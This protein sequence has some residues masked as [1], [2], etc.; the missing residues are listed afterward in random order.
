MIPSCMF[1]YSF[2][3]PFFSFLQIYIYIYVYIYIHTYMYGY[4]IKNDSSENCN[5]RLE[6]KKDDMKKEIS[7]INNLDYE[8]NIKEHKISSSEAFERNDKN[9]YNEKSMRNNCIE[10][11]ES[12]LYKEGSNK[13][14]CIERC[15]GREKRGKDYLEIS[16][17]LIYSRIR[18]HLDKNKENS[19]VYIY[20]KIILYSSLYNIVTLCD[21]YNYIRKN[22]LSKH[23]PKFFLYSKLFIMI[24]IKK[25]FYER[26]YIMCY[27]LSKLLLMEHMYDSFTITFFV[28]SS[29]LLNKISCI[30]NLAV[31]LRRNKKYIYYLFCNAALL[32]HFRQVERS[33]QIYK[34]I[35][36]S[37]KNIFSDL[38][39]YSLFNLIYSLQITQKAHQIIFLCKNLNKLF[40]HN[41]HVYILL[42]YYYFLNVIPTK[43][44]SSLIRAYNI[45]NY[46]PHIFYVLSYLALSLKKYA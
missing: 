31:E 24:N 6:N 34:Y 46:H 16:S 11:S 21:V 10:K 44:Y 41:I 5:N 26:N 22:K 18:F 28:N 3:F 42:S 40:F 2:Y 1:L 19:N 8:Q 45:Y 27:S 23:F 13:R 7:I 39:L 30:K 38:Y 35:V 12:N 17:F 33:I 32:L 15:E 9:K 36:D 43:S 25:S 37:Y 29:Y 20:K 14:E 4:N